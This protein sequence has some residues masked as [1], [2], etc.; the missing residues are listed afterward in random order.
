MI[1]IILIILIII[2]ILILV[3]IIYTRIIKD[4]LPKKRYKFNIGNLP[5]KKKAIKKA[6]KIINSIKYGIPIKTVNVMYISDNSTIFL[7]AGERKTIE[8]QDIISFDIG[9]NNKEIQYNPTNVCKVY[10]SD[11]EYEDILVCGENVP[12]NVRLN[13]SIDLSNKALMAS[14]ARY[15]NASLRLGQGILHSAI[16]AVD[17]N[18][19][20]LMLFITIGSIGIGIMIGLYVGV[21]FI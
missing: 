8:N 14:K 19:L 11:F 6:G 10:H 5:K 17:G 9:G 7:G 16:L 1:E 21:R 13:S 4:K 18:V 2:S 20:R 12:I 3:G 15:D